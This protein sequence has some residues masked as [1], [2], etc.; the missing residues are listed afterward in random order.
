MFFNVA[1]LC[2]TRAL[3]CILVGVLQ[4]H[5]INEVMTSDTSAAYLMFLMHLNVS[6]LWCVQTEFCMT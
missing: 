2:L 1:R 5:D 3:V 4:Q 6:K